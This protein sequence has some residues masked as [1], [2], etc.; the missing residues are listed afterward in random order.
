MKTSEIINESPLSTDAKSAV[1]RGGFDKKIGFA[2]RNIAKKVMEKHAQGDNWEIK[3]QAFDTGLYYTGGNPEE[4]QQV[5][6]EVVGDLYD[7]FQKGNRREVVRV[8]KTADDSE[9]TEWTVMPTSD[10][11]DLRKPKPEPQIVFRL[12]KNVQNGPVVGVHV[13]PK[14]Q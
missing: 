13:N 1:Q 10:P 11:S 12:F 9:A 4:A 8:A 2:L 5:G 14:F 7:L 6:L 3:Q